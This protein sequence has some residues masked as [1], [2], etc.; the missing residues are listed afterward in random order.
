MLCNELRNASTRIHGAQLGERDA[1]IFFAF[2]SLSASPPASP[3][4]TIWIHKSFQLKVI[5]FQISIFIFLVVLR[6]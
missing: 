6:V 3:N 1:S 4:W 5:K 2:S